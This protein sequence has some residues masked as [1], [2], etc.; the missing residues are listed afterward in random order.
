MTWRAAGLLL[1]LQGAA[2]LLAPPAATV[3]RITVA[4]TT[5]PTT[6]DPSGRMTLV[7]DVTPNPHVH[8]YA[9]GAKGLDP[10]SLVLTA[11][12]GV[13][14]GKPIFPAPD[15]APLSS[16]DEAPAYWK[17]FRVMQ[18]VTVKNA[19]L[20]VTVSGRLHY[21]ACDDKICYPTSSMPVSWTIRPA[22]A[23]K[24]R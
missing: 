18:P 24:R 8:V 14:L 6:P 4:A 5:V 9:A 23:P 22:A 21:Q 10:V 7:L 13:F 20:P 1:L 15:R 11:P 3:Q 2:P 19:V 12:D 17:E 16:T